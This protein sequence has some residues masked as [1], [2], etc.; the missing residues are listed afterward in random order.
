MYVGI[1]RYVSIRPLH[2]PLI[3]CH[4]SIPIVPDMSVQVSKSG[5]RLNDVRPIVFE[6]LEDDGTQMST[7]RSNGLV[8]GFAFGA[9]F[10]VVAL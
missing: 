6:L 5:L 4:F 2:N 7:E 1:S 9:F 3:Y 10:L 8:V